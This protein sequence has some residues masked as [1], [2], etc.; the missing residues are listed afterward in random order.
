MA[1]GTEDH[2]EPTSALPS[3]R[4]TTRRLNLRQV[5]DEA[6]KRAVMRVLGARQ[7]QPRARRR[8]CSASAGRRCT[9]SCTG[10]ASSEPSP[11]HAIPRERS[12]EPR[13]CP[14]CRAAVSC[15]CWSI[16]CRA[17]S[18]DTPRRYVASA[19]GYLAKRDYKAA[20]IELKNALQTGPRTTPRRAC[21]SRK[22]LLDTGDPVGA[23][24]EVRKAL[25]L[26]YSP[27]G[28][29]YPLLARAL[30]AQGEFKK[31][32]RELGERQARD[33]ARPQPIS[34]ASLAT[35]HVGAGQSPEA[36]R[37]ASTRALARDARR[38]A[39]AGACRRSSP[40]RRATA[41][42]A[43]ELRRNRA[44]ERAR[45]IIEAL[46]AQGAD[47]RSRSGDRTARSRR[48]TKCVEAHP[49]SLAARVRSHLA[50]GA[51]AA[52]TTGAQAQLDKIKELAPDEI[53][54]V[55]CRGTRRLCARRHAAT[56]ASSSSRSGAQRRTICRLCLLSGLVDYQLGSNARPRRRCARCWRKA[57]RRR[58][59]ARGCWQRPICAAARP[60][61][62]RNARAG[63]AAR[64]ATI[65]SCCALAA[66]P[67]SHRQHAK[68]RGVLR[69][70]DRD[71]QGRRRQARCAWR[72][73]ALRRR[74]A[75]RAFSDSRRC[76]QGRPAQYAGRSRAHQ[77]AH[78][79]ARVRQGARRGRRAREEA[80]RQ[81][82]AAQ[83]PRRR[84]PRQARHRERARELRAGARSSSRPILAAALQPRAAR[85][86]RE[87]TPTARASATSDAREGSEE[88]AGAARARRAAAL[89]R[90]A[91]D[92]V[93]PSIE[94]GDRGQSRRRSRAR[95]AL[96]AYYMQQ[97]DAKAA[98]GRGA[99]GAGGVARQPA[100]PGSARRSAARRRRNQSGARRRSRAWSTLQPEN[101][102]RATAPGRRAERAPRTTTARSRPSRKALALQAR[103]AAGVAR[104]LTKSHDRA[105]PSPT[106]HRRCAQ[107]AEGAA[108]HARVG[109]ALEGELLAAEG[110]WAEA[111]RASTAGCQA[112]TEPAHCCSRCSLRS[113]S[114]GKTPKRTA[115]AEQVAQGPSRR[116]RRCAD[117]V[118]EQSDG[119]QGL[120]RRCRTV[121]GDRWSSSPTTR[122]AL[123]NLAWL[124]SEA[125]RPEG[126]RVCR[127]GL[128]SSRRQSASVLDTLGWILVKTR[129][130]RARHRVAAHGQ[131]RSR[132]TSR[133]SPASRAGA[134][135]GR[136]QG[137]GAKELETVAKLPTAFARAARGRE[138]AEGALSLRRCARP[139]QR[140]RRARLAAT[141][142]P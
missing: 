21:C 68:G 116:I 25:D 23:E 40:R 35:A 86:R 78:A 16:A 98:A 2:A 74:D 110:K 139:L 65:P 36:A 6:E 39:R 99:G 127:A 135:Q 119:Q 38:S 141:H 20:I 81:P 104:C 63:V 90:T 142:A 26:K 124:L 61:R 4:P 96:I 112:P 56:R 101:P 131:R 80:A 128:S 52:R 48:S 13:P 134:D 44:A 103:P 93:R 32:I 5:R 133:D 41:A 97:K 126:A 53:R 17:C 34:A 55:V 42:E 109:Y 37:S 106:A 107:A 59:A 67:T 43:D 108:R 12:H 14:V 3:R 47:C 33:P 111:A 62:P 83:P 22:T 132:R 121:P 120:S 130:H 89:T 64:A 60:A 138:A 117:L 105:G 24:T 113:Q 118:G 8:R 122:S 84:L 79:A 57:A 10:S 46:L 102:A 72:R 91:P 9:T 29:S 100:D 70:R 58:N 7:R 73:C 75:T 11:S 66:R 49:D 27:D 76:R 19:K 51:R 125:R 30:L 31:L 87:A 71:R 69:A 88:R 15:G 114:A 45:P 85:H 95:L 140:E 77:R 28:Q 1:D 54:N 92:E 94:Q 136:R 82:A 137:C 18:A 123:N 50:A 129:R 115:M